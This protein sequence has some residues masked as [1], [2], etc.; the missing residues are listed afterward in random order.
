MNE[1]QS[2][3]RNNIGAVTDP[4]AKAWLQNWTNPFSLIDSGYLAPEGADEHYSMGQRFAS[5]Y[6]EL[7]GATGFNP[8]RA[9]FQNTQVERAAV[10]SQSF[11]AGLYNQRGDLPNRGSPIYSFN[12]PKKADPTLRPFDTCPP[13]VTQSYKSGNESDLSVWLTQRVLPLLPR[14][15]KLFGATVDLKLYKTIHTTCA[16]EFAVFNRTHHFCS[17]LNETDFKVWEYAGDIERYYTRSYGLSIAVEIGAPLLQEFVALMKSKFSSLSSSN[18]ET[19]PSTS[20]Y[21]RFAHA[22][23][24]EPILSILGLFK[25]AEPLRAN[26]T[27]P[28]ID[29]RKF[30]S[31]LIFPFGSN[32]FMHGYDCG[33]DSGLPDRF[34]IKMMQ[35]ERDVLI[36]GCAAQGDVS[37]FCSFS[38]FQRAYADQLAINFTTLCSTTTPNTSPSVIPASEPTG[39]AP[40][41]YE[42]K[43]FH[44]IYVWGPAVLMVTFA[45]AFIGGFCVGTYRPMVRRTEPLLSGGESS[46]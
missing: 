20:A 29:A 42:G 21:F 16:Y 45:V 8:S 27:W 10:S 31:S 22:E 9:T 39:S 40:T 15:S 33:E 35:N 37:P 6:S 19:F 46:Y 34:L 5:S 38:E 11:A 41:T 14:L 18:A 44:P 7:V 32:L 24:M 25:D 13:F 2:F 3:V 12:L 36:P 43:P 30:R 1:L 17:L 23:T 28:Q 26:W 4:V